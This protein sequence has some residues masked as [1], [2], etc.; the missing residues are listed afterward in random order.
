M[1]KTFSNRLENILKVNETYTF[2]YYAW[3]NTFSNM[4]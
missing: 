4:F 2:L 3:E 1:E